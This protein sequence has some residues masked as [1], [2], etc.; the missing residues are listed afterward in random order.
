MSVSFLPLDAVKNA[1]ALDDAQKA[2]YIVPLSD[3]DL[4]IGENGA[5]LCLCPFGTFSVSS[6]A[7]EQICQKLGLPL[8][9]LRRCPVWLQRQNLSFW[10]SRRQRKGGNVLLRTKGE[11]LRAF[12]SPS[13]SP[14]DHRDLLAVLESIPSVGEKLLPFQFALTEK[15]LHL[16]LLDPEPFEVT[17]D[18]QREKLHFGVYLRNSEVGFAK[19][20]L[21]A[22]L[23]RHACGNLFVSETVFARVHLW[24]DKKEIK[25][26]LSSALERAVSLTAPK[27]AEA[28]MAS[29]SVSIP[30]GAKERVFQHAA[31]M[32]GQKA[33]KELLAL[34]YER[35]KET[36]G[37]GET[38]FTLVQAIARAAS[39]LPDAETRFS[40]SRFATSLLPKGNGEVPFLFVPSWTRR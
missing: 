6:I 32:A 23:H 13:F 7:Q 1:I 16:S 30:S 5:W 35:E 34:E 4:E 15:S 11:V 26:R 17:W 18:G 22:C 38:L 29:L 31:K 37:S 12:L 8:S 14:F 10:L 24:I 36:S 20:A 21:S 27:V 39:Q 33:L 2:D 28:L 3:L 19:V 40:L 25:E 9:Y